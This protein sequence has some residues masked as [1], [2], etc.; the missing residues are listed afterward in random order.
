MWG[1]GVK[2]EDLVECVRTLKQ[3]DIVIG[4]HI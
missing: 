1:R 3:V 4:Q 2:K